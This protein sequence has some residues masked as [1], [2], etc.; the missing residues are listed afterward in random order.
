MADTNSG[1]GKKNVKHHRP[2]NLPLSG[3]SLDANVFTTEKSE[4]EYCL[5]QLQGSAGGEGYGKRFFNPSLLISPLVTKEATLSSKI[6]GTISTVSDVYRYEAGETPE[7]S[8]TAE[9]ANYRKAINQAIGLVKAGRKINKTY[10]KAIHQTLLTGVRHKGVL[11]DFR[12]GDVWIGERETDPIEKAIYVPPESV[13]VEPYID[14][15]LEYIENGV[16]DPLTKAALAH[17]Q[18]EAIHPFTDGNGRIG[19]LLIPLILFEKNRISLPILYM[20]G[21]FDVHREEY[22]SALHR[23][24]ET[25]QYEEW[26]MFF[27]R[28]V[29]KQVEET[30]NLITQINKLYDEVKT[31]VS[32]SKSQYLYEFLGYL[33]ERPIFNPT[34]AQ[35]TLGVPTYPPIQ[36]LVRNFEQKGVIRPVNKEFIIDKRLKLYSFDQLL[37]LLK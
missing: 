12:K 7:Y 29:S 13:Y 26:L 32:G 18:F 15:L 36:G 6:E 31:E 37:N 5:G 23:V 33:F 28:S 10:L 19:R 16:E 1:S 21:Y 9:V 17:Y 4:A 14:N 24:D 3:I 35:K 20:S 11:G 2:K 34:D 25:L 30:Q 22:R 27:F 8:G